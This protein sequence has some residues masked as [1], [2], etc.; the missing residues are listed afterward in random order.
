VDKAEEAKKKLV[1]NA[2]VVFAQLKDVQLC[3]SMW[4]D[5]GHHR[6]GEYFGVKQENGPRGRCRD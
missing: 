3:T 5:V 6:D 1:E 2:L 4:A